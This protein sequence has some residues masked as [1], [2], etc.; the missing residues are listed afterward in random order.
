MNNKFFATLLTGLLYTSN[1]YAQTGEME[2]PRN[3]KNANIIINVGGIYIHQNKF[4]GEGAMVSAQFEMDEI[5]PNNKWG[6][7]V[8]SKLTYQS[9]FDENKSNVSYMDETEVVVGIHS[10]ENKTVNWYFESGDR[11]QSFEQGSNKLWQNYGYVNRLGVN[12]SQE[13]GMFNFALEYRDGIKNEIGYRT[14]LVSSDKLMSLSYTHV[15][16]YKSIGLTLNT[17]F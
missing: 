17:Y 13:I 4:K 16:D 15:G 8:Y 10:K 2:N 7:K 9:S 12:V 3:S 5:F 6:L 14:S 1:S 11:K